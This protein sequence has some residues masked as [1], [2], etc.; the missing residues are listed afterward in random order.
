MRYIQCTV[1]TAFPGRSKVALLLFARHPR[2]AAVP[3]ILSLQNCSLLAHI[4]RLIIVALGYLAGALGDCSGRVSHVLPCLKSATPGPGP[5][6]LLLSP[7]VRCPGV[8]ALTRVCERDLQSVVVAEAFADRRDD[9]LCKLFAQRLILTCPPRASGLQGLA[10]HN[11]RAEAANDQT[12]E[13]GGLVAR[14]PVDV[15]AGRGPEGDGG[16]GGI[17]VCDVYWVVAEA[18]RRCSR[19]MAGGGGVLGALML[20]W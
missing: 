6:I 9:G 12:P 4:F 15:L 13:N 19:G 18:R 5:C 8:V 17:C 7:A 14:S 10:Y 1:V 3:I 2:R 20:A 16:H 11:Q